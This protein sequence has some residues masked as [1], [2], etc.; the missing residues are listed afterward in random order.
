[1]RFT[2]QLLPLLRTASPE[3]SRVVSV[4][5]PGGESRT[6]FYLNDLDLKSNFSIR[7]AACHAITMTNFSFEEMAKQN[8]TVSFVHTYPGVVKTAFY[9][10]A[11]FA[12]RM[13][14]NLLLTILSTVS[15]WTVDIQ[16]SGERHLYAATS[17]AYPPKSGEDGGID[18]GGEEVMKGSDGKVGSGAYL[19]GSSGD[20]R[21]NEEILKELRDNGAGMNIWQHT[22]NI[23]KSVRG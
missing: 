10:E 12:V 20:F 9:K 8:P 18:I 15:P 13:A 5:A 23:F 1:M 21:G 11:G 17:S 3:L 2:Q 6:S 22:M 19:I 16:E 7:T 4:L 14:S